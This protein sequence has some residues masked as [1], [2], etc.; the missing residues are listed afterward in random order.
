[1]KQF[2]I[3][4][5][6]AAKRGCSYTGHV[7]LL[8]GREMAVW[9]SVWGTQAQ[10]AWFVWGFFLKKVRFLGYFCI[11]CL[12]WRPKWPACFRPWLCLCVAFLAPS[13]SSNTALPPLMFSSSW[14]RRRGFGCGEGRDKARENERLPERAAL[15]YEYYGRGFTALVTKRAESGAF[16][17]GAELEH[18]LFLLLSHFWFHVWSEVVK[19]GTFVLPST[20]VRLKAVLFEGWRGGMGVIN[21]PLICSSTDGSIENRFFR[22][23]PRR[24]PNCSLSALMRESRWPLK[25]RLRKQSFC[26]AQ[27]SWSFFNIPHVYSEV[28]NTWPFKN[29]PTHNSVFLCVGSCWCTSTKGELQSCTAFC[30][31]YTHILLSTKG[32]R[33]LVPRLLGCYAARGILRASCKPVVVCL[34]PLRGI[35]E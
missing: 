17:N 3:L 14:D 22:L 27:H 7:L 5:S 15:R 29:Q 4:V 11:I 1:M 6:A 32:G 13:L 23:Q 24:P 25:R 35:E 31:S 28:S 18:C 12:L 10:N 20:L 34:L 16:S 33:C 8:W 26:R 19:P 30:W 2:A 9:P 21:F